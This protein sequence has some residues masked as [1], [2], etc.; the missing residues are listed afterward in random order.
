[1]TQ[2]PTDVRIWCAPKTSGVPGLT[3]AELATLL[4]PLLPGGEGTFTGLLDTPSSYSGEGE[5]PVQ[6]NVGENGLEFVTAT[7]SG[8]KIAQVIPASISSLITLSTVMP[9]DDTIPQQTEGDEILT[10]TIT[11]TNINSKIIVT[12]KFYA[13]NVVVASFS[14]TA[15]I[16]RDATSDALGAVQYSA[17]AESTTIALDVNDIPATALVATTFKL[18]SGPTVAPNTFEVNGFNGSRKYGG[19]ASCTLTAWEILP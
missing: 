18:R 6:V 17:E 7:V 10:V 2:C 19:V 16:F 12:A 11:P 3:L 8:G 5:K 9:A 14:G 1:M 15:A 13:V 4:A